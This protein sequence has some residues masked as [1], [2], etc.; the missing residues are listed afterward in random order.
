MQHI[1]TFTQLKLISTSYVYSSI[2]QIPTTTKAPD[3]CLDI[4]NSFISGQFKF[5]NTIPSNTYK[6]IYNITQS[7]IATDII[8]FS[9]YD[10]LIYNNLSDCIKIYFSNDTRL[11]V[12]LLKPLTND[13]L[14]NSINDF[15]LNNNPNNPKIVNLIEKIYLKDDNPISNQLIIK[16][17][18]L[19]DCSIIKKSITMDLNSINSL[20]NLNNIS[21]LN[22]E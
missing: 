3:F 18:L 17:I 22:K 7:Y 14:I 21:N 15:H 5:K 2:L 12:Q 11:V 16:K 6:Y 4:Y 8:I 1:T 13:I 9:T 20:N 19:L 10:I